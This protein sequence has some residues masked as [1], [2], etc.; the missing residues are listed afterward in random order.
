MIEIARDQRLGGVVEN[1]LELTL[2]SRLHDGVHFF[3][4]GGALGGEAQV[5][6]RDIDGRY[7]D[8][9]A[10]KLAIEFGQQTAGEFFAVFHT[11]LVKGIDVQDRGANGRANIGEWRCLQS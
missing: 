3:D 9:V 5:D 4:A 11:V 6:N 8:G 2:G 7:A 10:I 1:A